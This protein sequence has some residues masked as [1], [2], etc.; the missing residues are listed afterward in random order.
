MVPKLRLKPPLHPD[1]ANLPLLLK[2]V[3]PNTSAC[4]IPA[5]TRWA[6]RYQVQPRDVR[7]RCFPPALLLLLLRGRG[8]PGVGG[9][10]GLGPL[11]AGGVGVGVPRAVLVGAVADRLLVEVDALPGRDHLGPG[12]TVWTW[13]DG[14]DGSSNR[15]VVQSLP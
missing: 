11:L 9:L 15:I 8:G 10:G 7:T 12:E 3:N 4:H 14:R 13:S 1:L 2:G 5:W 6:S